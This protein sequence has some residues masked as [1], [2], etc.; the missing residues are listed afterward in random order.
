[1]KLQ[2]YRTKL[3]AIS[4][5]IA[6]GLFLLSP[7]LGIPLELVPLVVAYGFVCLGRALGMW[8]CYERER[9]EHREAQELRMK[10][11]DS[12]EKAFFRVTH[13]GKKVP[14]IGGRM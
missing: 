13:K 9:I 12:I 2:G 5:S 4:H 1:M 10:P 7:F 11:F 6:G 8:G 3:G 14:I